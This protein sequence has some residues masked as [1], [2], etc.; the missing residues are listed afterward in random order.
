MKRV[1][2]KIE[3]LRVDIPKKEVTVEQLFYSSWL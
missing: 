2:E 1:V 3:E